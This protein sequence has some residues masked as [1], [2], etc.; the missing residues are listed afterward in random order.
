[1]MMAGPLTPDIIYPFT[2]KSVMWDL[3]GEEENK[4]YMENNIGQRR[5]PKCQIDVG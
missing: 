2:D 5:A 1:M 4:R 3:I